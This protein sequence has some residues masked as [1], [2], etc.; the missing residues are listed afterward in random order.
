M[1][2]VRSNVRGSHSG[3]NLGIVKVFRLS[4]PQ[5]AQLPAVE[6][7]GDECNNRLFWWKDALVS[8]VCRVSIPALYV[9]YSYVVIRSRIA[10]IASYDKAI[11][12]LMTSVHSAKHRANNNISFKKKNVKDV[13]GTPSNHR[14]SHSFMGNQT[15]SVFDDNVTTMTN[16]PSH[17]IS[18][19]NNDLNKKY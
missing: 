13:S 1:I 7:R 18:N 3:N 4:K 10:A 5:T 8:L 11:P 17:Q 19:Y 6:K 9:V 14:F 2:G 12:S 16:N 15:G